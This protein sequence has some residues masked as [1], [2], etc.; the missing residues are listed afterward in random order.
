MGKQ[1]NIGDII[2]ISNYIT[3]DNIEIGQHSFVVLHNKA[4]K[5]AGIEIDLDLELEFDLVG[6]V[7]SSIKNE[8]HRKKIESYYPK[9][10]IITFNDAQVTN[11]NQKDGFIKANQLHYFQ[12]NKIKYMKIGKVTQSTLNK[13][14]TL[15]ELNDKNGDL[16]KNFNNII[17]LANDKKNKK[18]TQP[19]G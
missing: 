9:D 3:P 17:S 13:L 7:M 15:I 1:L 2:V 11:G 6:A 16:T 4:G 19:A 10:M 12:R 5:I 18:D 8:E 14:L